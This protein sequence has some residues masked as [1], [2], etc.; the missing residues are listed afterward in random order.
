MSNRS[1]DTQ[2]IPS[3][4]SREESQ[5]QQ[6]QQQQQQNAHI[7]CTLFIQKSVYLCRSK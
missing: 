7:Y 6:Q 5:Q 3:T 4:I 2:A 1:K